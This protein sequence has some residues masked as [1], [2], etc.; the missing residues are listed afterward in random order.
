MN[1]QELKNKQKELDEKKYRQSE[2]AKQDLAGRMEY[3]DGCYFVKFDHEKGHVICNLDERSKIENQVCAKNYV[4]RKENES[5][6]VQ[7]EV[8]GKRPRTNR[9]TNNG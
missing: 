3:C 1:E 9:K 5:R 7:K 2:I 4:R 6:N 8:V